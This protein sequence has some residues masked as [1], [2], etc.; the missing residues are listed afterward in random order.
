[1]QNL[2]IFTNILFLQILK[3]SL[4][5]GSNLLL[6]EWNCAVYTGGG[7]MYTTVGWLT[8]SLAT[9]QLFSEC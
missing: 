5:L 1:M 8:P 6:V 4:V 2:S 3:D 9:L 7:S